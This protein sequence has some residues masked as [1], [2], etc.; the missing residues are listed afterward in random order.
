LCG[1]A[2]RLTSMLVET[3]TAAEPATFALA[4]LMCLHAARLPARLDAHGDLTSLL[5]QDRSRWDVA[6][7]DRGRALLERASPGTVAT[8][9]HLEAAIAAVHAAS[10]SVA[11]TNWD[12]IVELYDRLMALAPS[13]VVALNRAVAVAQRD[14]PDAGLLAIRTIPDADRL[15]RYP[16]YP[17]AIGELELR[18]GDLASA[19]RAFAAAVGLARNPLERRFLERRLRTAETTSHPAPAGPA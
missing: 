11:C 18:R 5:D 19:A 3:E 12:A 6:L 15:R 1:E 4:A 16:F 13:P 2:I 8:Q 17:A 9:Y 14:G 7:I 10:P